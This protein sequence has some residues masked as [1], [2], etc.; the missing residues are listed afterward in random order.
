SYYSNANGNNAL[1]NPNGITTSGTYYIKLSNANTCS[2]IKPLSLPV[3]LPLYLIVTDPSPVCAPGS[4]DITA[5]SVTAGS[6][7]GQLSYYSDANGN[8]G[9]QNPNA[10]TISG[11]YYIKLAN[12]NS[13]S[14]IKPVTVTVNPQP[15]LIV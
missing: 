6:D 12:A 13:C 11:T 7:A 4:V 1:Q 14:V 9:L 5:A 2:V 15:N 8:N 3:T 10:I